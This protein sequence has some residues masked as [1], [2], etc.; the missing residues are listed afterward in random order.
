MGTLSGKKARKKD[1]GS[2]SDIKR[3]IRHKKAK[4]QKKHK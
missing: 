3:Q 1:G 2:K 4:R